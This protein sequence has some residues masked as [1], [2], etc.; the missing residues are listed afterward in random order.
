MTTPPDSTVV[1]VHGAFCGSWT[2]RDLTPEL[3]ARGARWIAPDL[4][5]T[6]GDPEV[7][8]EDDA[9]SVLGA[10]KAAEP[11]GRVILVGHSYGGAVIAEAAARIPRLAALVFLAALV[12]EVGESPSDAARVVKVRT[13]LDEAM[14]VDDGLIRLD[15]AR[16]GEALMGDCDADATDWVT[17]RL[18]PQSL[19]SFRSPR[20]AT[21]PA[22]LRRYV[23]CRDDHAIDPAVQTLLAAR[24]DEVVDLASAH[25]PQF[26]MPRA[27]V[28]AILGTADHR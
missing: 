27:C 7:T 2:W 13:L 22:V 23:R 8:L 4:P 26:S 14:S 12:P 17:A 10:V 1:L 9:A 5:S 3:D 19:R 15:P 11:T 24:C 28:D 25:S 18:R 21:N 20:V 6:S 16:A